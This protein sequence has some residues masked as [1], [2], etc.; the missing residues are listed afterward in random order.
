MVFSSVIYLINCL[1][2]S[3][4]TTSPYFS[5][6]KTNLDYS[7]LRTLGCLCFPLI[8]PYNTYNLQT[9][10]LPCIFIGY[11]QGQKDYRCYNV[12]THKTYVYSHVT[13]DELNFPFKIAPTSFNPASDPDES[14]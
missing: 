12:D 1:P 13:F 8:K 14:S 2:N 7:F 3:S 4:N 11:L 10:G 5:L 9:R 6:H